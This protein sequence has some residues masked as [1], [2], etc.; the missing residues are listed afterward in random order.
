MLELNAYFRLH[1]TVERIRKEAIA[2]YWEKENRDDIIAT[3]TPRQMN[4]L[5]ILH[6]RGP[7][8]LQE[9]MKMTGLSASAS[10]AAV[11]KL[12]KLGI[13]HRETDETNRRF[14][15]V[16]ITRELLGHMEK[17]DRLFRGKVHAALSSCTSG[18]IRELEEAS[19]RILKSMDGAAEK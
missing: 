2:E 3:L 16:S 6:K 5:M 10:S 15:R 8:T 9:I 4:Y 13:L 17:I 12:V 19:G 14:I 1:Q 11:D 7:C 18:E